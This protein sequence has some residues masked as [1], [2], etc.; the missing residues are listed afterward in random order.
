MLDLQVSSNCPSVGAT[1]ATVSGSAR[2]EEGES[3]ARRS[4]NQSQI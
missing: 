2:T 3:K 4:R 1:L